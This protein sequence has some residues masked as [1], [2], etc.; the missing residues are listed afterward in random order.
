MRFIFLLEFVSR[1]VNNQPSSSTTTSANASASQFLFA[2]SIP[3]HVPSST[4]SPAELARLQQQIENSESMVQIKY[5]HFLPN[6][7][8]FILL[9]SEQLY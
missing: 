9:T 4:T 3:L 6:S 1:L 8:L 5:I 7:F 2:S